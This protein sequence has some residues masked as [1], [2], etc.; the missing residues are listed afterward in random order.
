MKNPFSL[1]SYWQLCPSA[2]S[3]AD[4]IAEKYG[5][6]EYYQSIPTA[7]FQYNNGEYLIWAVI[8]EEY[9]AQGITFDVLKSYL[10]TYYK[11][12]TNPVVEEN[13]YA[14]NYVKPGSMN[15][16][17][18]RDLFLYSRITKTERPKESSGTHT[19]SSGRTHGG[20]GGSF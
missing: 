9:I 5:D 4:E 3:K 10:D 13:D 20:R 6:W 18:S 17:V 15:I 2:G 12:A 8:P 11:E 1:L 19:S 7:T 14:A 16:S